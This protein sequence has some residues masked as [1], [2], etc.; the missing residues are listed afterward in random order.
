MPSWRGCSPEKGR[1]PELG[2]HQSDGRRSL[3]S[4]G[5]PGRGPSR[6]NGR[7]CPAS[8]H[9]WQTS[10]R[11]QLACRMSISHHIGTRQRSQCGWWSGT[12]TR[13]ACSSC[14]RRRQNHMPVQ[15]AMPPSPR[16]GTGD[17]CVRQSGISTKPTR[18]SSATNGPHA[19]LPGASGQNVRML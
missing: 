12:F 11:C 7:V 13:A 1:L 6:D 14:W 16:C 15:V 17:H 2:G 3:S 8:G 9:L 18:N 4:G 5:R 19:A 10:V